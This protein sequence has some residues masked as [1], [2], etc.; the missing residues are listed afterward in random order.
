MAVC[1]FLYII[2]EIMRKSTARFPQDATPVGAEAAREN[3]VLA[4]LAG[5]ETLA[6][7]LSTSRLIADA[8]RAGIVDGSLPPGTP[9]RQ[10]AVARRFA[11]SAIPVREALRQLESEGWVRTETH[12]GATVSPLVADE[13]REIYEIRA[14]LESLAIGFAIERHTDET[15]RRAQTRLDAALAEADAARYVQHNEAF[16]LSLYQPADKPHLL[17]MIDGLH[18]RGERYL[19]LKLDRPLHKAK[20]DEEHRALLAAV[21]DR[22]RAL[23]QR[24]V[25]EHLLS[26]G[27]LLHR[28]VTERQAALAALAPRPR[29][30][31]AASAAAPAPVPV[32][33][34]RS[35][36]T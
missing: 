19:R 32:V 13:A 4:A 5:P 21:R 3:G 8:L 17:E 35:T 29:A 23:A 1:A 20:S 9:L 27:D 12:K 14:A 31:R 36:D 33:P 30:R 26:T 28:F 10:D 7:R 6:P 16:H 11:V 25:T 18:R 2:F 22:D 24:L 34:T 15:L